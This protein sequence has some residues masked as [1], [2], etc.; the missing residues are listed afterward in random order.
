[1]VVQTQAMRR[2]LDYVKT[3]HP[4]HARIHLCNR[5]A[6]RGRGRTDWVGFDNC[7]R[8]MSLKHR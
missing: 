7:I 1:M 5:N 2:A 8:N 6:N 3:R 4:A